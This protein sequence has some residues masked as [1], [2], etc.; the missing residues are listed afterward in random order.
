MAPIDDALHSL[1]SLK[2]KEQPNFTKVAENIVITKVHCQSAGRGF[3]A[4]YNRRTK[5]NAS[6]IN[7]RKKSFYY[8]STAL[9]QKDY[10]LHNK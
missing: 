4:L 7:P 6:L 2:L 8:I 1:K 9:L 5:I 3:R 10:L